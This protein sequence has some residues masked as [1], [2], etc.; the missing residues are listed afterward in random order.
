MIQKVTISIRNG[1]KLHGDI[2]RGDDNKAQPLIIF[3][4]GFKG[5]KDW[6]G[7]PYM[8]EQISQEGYT[9][10]CFNF[11]HNG[12]SN[13]NP[14]EFTRLDLFAKNTF[15]MEINE[16]GYIIDYFYGNEKEFKIDKEKIALIGHSR[17]GGVSIIRA[18]ID[19]R[20][21]CLVTLSSVSH[22]DRYSEK[23]K[24]QWRERGF[25]EVENSRTKQ[26]MK[27]DVMLLDDL[28]QNKEM[29]NV[30]KAVSNISIPFLIIH[31]K[32]DL[33][34]RYTEAEKLYKNSNKQFTEFLLLNNT[35][36][37]FGVS[38]PFQGTT[39]AFGKVIDK[40]RSFLKTYL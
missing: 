19:K 11:S 38:H 9:A 37:T 24:T 29:L 12:V 22:F 17:G 25:I 36:H 34:V 3:A 28:E 14:E 27:L 1:I 33:A 4:H 7:F 6:G 10:A 39:D 31:G 13:E 21:K 23:L 20:V 8:L 16:L 32:E 26:M 40:V 5:F 18:S 30:T 2:R 15:T 35:G